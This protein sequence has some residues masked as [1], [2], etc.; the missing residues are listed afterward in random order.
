[1][2]K[3]TA[4][5][6]KKIVHITTGHNL[7][8]TRIFYKECKTLTEAG[9]DVVLV[10]PYDKDEVISGVQIRAIP[11]PASRLQ[12]ITQTAWAAY[13]RAAAEKADVYHFHDYELIPAGILLKLTGKRVIYDIHEN[14][15]HRIM[16]DYN[17]DI[18]RWLRV[19]MAKVGDVLEK[20]AVCFFDG[21]VAV[22][23]AIAQRFPQ[24]KTEL[25]QNFPLLGEL[26]SD[27]NVPFSE[28]P[29]LVVYAGEITILRG[30][31][32]I[33][34]AMALLPDSLGA[35][36]VLLGNFS[37]PQLEEEVRA[38]P[39]WE[40]VRYLGWKTRDAL[41]P[42][43]AQARVGLVLFHPI[44]NHIEAQPNKLFEYMSMS[45]PVV[46]S[47]F[48][49][50]RKIIGEINC[51]LLVDPLDSEAVAEAVKWLLQNPEEAENM[52]QRGQQAVLKQYNWKHESR[53]L[54]DFYTKVTK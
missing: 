1:M 25:V 9:Y 32:E 2:M 7:F 31:R 39:G 47:D 14:L 3:K 12:R 29:P 54:L 26:Q 24:R 15:P 5:K 30:V 44:P 40:R 21:A 18:H 28:K 50:W 49:L 35:E 11:K 51:G 52:G 13:R 37:P 36:L 20:M 4:L 19:V 43:V 8:D 23:P 33:I 46:A 41:I 38:L 42:L 27:S 22:T 17:K 34:R 48:P 16:G 10:V 53:K 6:K 45:I